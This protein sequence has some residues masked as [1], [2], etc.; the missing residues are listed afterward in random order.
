[1][2]DFLS[3]LD[4]YRLHKTITRISK[5]YI[6]LL[7]LAFG[8]LVVENEGTVEKVD[9]DMGASREASRTGVYLVN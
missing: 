1:M 5:M 9:I 7:D 3:T 4:I 6:F 8:D 2:W